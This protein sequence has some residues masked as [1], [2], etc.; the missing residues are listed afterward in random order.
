MTTSTSIHSV[1]QIE[2][3]VEEFS[4][5][6]RP[7]FDV[8]T[9]EI[10]GDSF[11]TKNELKL[12]TAGGDGP[13]LAQAFGAVVPAEA[14][15]QYNLGVM[16]HHGTGVP[17]DYAEAVKWWRLAAEQGF[18]RAQSNLG[19]M[20]ANGEGV[21]QDYDEAMRLYRLAAE[22]GL[23]RAQHNLGNMYEN[24]RGVAVDDAEALRWYRLAAEQGLA[25]AQFNLGWMYDEGT[26]VA[27]DDAEAVRWYRLAA[28][29]EEDSGCRDR[30]SGEE[31]EE[32]SA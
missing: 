27:V 6:D 15:A 19:V 29:Q 7:S 18:A 30:A 1:R 17:K 16:Y 21:A 10:T 31:Q 4:P 14:A 23:A 28:E 9:I 3:S 12:F 22:Q 25:D 24:G 5:D 13:G 2:V 11:S 26:G 8:I 32:D 20:Y